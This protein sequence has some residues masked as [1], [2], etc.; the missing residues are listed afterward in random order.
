MTSY[1]NRLEREAED[2]D[3]NFD[4]A[5]FSDEDA[6]FGRV[7]TVKEKGFYILPSQL[8]VNVWSAARDASEE[9]RADLNET[10][11]NVFK[12]IENSAV[13]TASEE[14]LTGL[15]AD[16]DVN[17]PKLGRSTLER[18]KKLFKILDAVAGLNLGDFTD[19]SIDAFGDA[20][21]F[22]MTRCTRATPGSPGANS[23]RR[24]RSR[25]C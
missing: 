14:K 8:F 13:G 22:L 7:E 4:Y 24:K 15:F 12:S 10:L 11:S 1:I 5:A 6:E 9:E 23:S 18:G 21:E 3:P 20:Y 16:V 25:S 17:S 2:G 19:N